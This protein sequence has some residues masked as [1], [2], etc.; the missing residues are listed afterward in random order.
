MYI[1]DFSLQDNNYQC[2]CR[3]CL[4]PKGDKFI[5]LFNFIEQN[6]VEDGYFRFI[7]LSFIRLK[8]L[9]NEVNITLSNNNRLINPD[10]IDFYEETKDIDFSKKGDFDVFILVPPKENIFKKIFRIAQEPLI[11]KLNRVPGTAKY[12]IGE[13]FTIKDF[14]KYAGCSCNDLKK[15]LPPEYICD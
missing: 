9:I 7:Q 6:C 3:V 1:G 4:I 15:I 14:I 13:S 10:A 11:Y 5:L 2:N 12:D 8:S